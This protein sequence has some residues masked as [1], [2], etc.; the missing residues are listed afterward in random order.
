MR[1]TSRP[2]L[3]HLFAALTVVALA[4]V[5]L[6]GSPARGTAKTPAVAISAF[7]ADEAVKQ[8]TAA[9]GTLRFDVAENATL[10]TWSGEPE[11]ADGVPVHRTAFVSQG[12]IYPDG[13]L[14]NGNGVNP[15]GSPEFPEKVLGQW[16]CW[17]W[18]VGAGAAEGAA[19]WLTTHLVSFGGVSGEATL[20]SEGYSIDDLAV[21]LERAIT[22][23]TGTFAGARGV[24]K[25]TNLGFNAT[26]GM[27]FRYEFSLAEA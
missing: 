2:K 12:Y 7:T 9:A 23:G 1:A 10:F 19:P 8:I 13:T 21:A 11:L 4:A 26:E 3:T 18:H 5:T 22:G 27:N 17:G 6:S 16:S 14:T 24:Q 20:V 15:D 25:E